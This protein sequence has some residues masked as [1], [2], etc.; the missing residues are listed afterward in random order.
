MT[1]I[2]IIINCYKILKVLHVN[3]IICICFQSFFCSLP[4][5]VL[6]LACDVICRT[7]AICNIA[8]IPGI[9]IDT[10]RRSLFALHYD[11][12]SCLY[13][14]LITALIAEYFELNKFWSMIMCS[15][16]QTVGMPAMLDSIR[17]PVHQLNTIY[18]WETLLS[19]IS[20][21]RKSHSTIL[22]CCCFIKRVAFN[23]RLNLFN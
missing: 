12:N 13:I 11:R 10:C 1:I 7:P 15:E 20:E 9:L 18:A 19:V 4:W 3:L 14:N 23:F 22:N 16:L 8:V 6:F 2:I 17:H 5:F 21:L